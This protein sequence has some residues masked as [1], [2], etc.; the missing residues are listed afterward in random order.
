MFSLLNKKTVCLSPL[1]KTEELFVFVLLQLF[2]GCLLKRQ[3]RELPTQSNRKEKKSYPIHFNSCWFLASVRF[4]FCHPNCTDK[5]Q[6]VSL[7]YI[8]LRVMC[9]SDNHPSNRTK[10]DCR[11]RTCDF[12]IVLPTELFRLLGSGN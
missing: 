9:S 10:I 2:C 11:I 4:G 3:F 12:S 8:F 6:T 5:D 1:E 7:W